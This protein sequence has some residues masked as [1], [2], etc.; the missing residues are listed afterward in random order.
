M[1]FCIVCIQY[2]VKNDDFFSD[3]IQVPGPMLGLSIAQSSITSL[4]D[5]L[6]F[7]LLANTL[8]QW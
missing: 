2:L 7:Y 1:Y 4:S 5:F 8:D 6:N 3:G